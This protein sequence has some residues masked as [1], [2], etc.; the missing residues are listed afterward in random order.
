MQSPTGIGSIVGGHSSSPQARVIVAPDRDSS[1][2]EAGSDGQVVVT[3]GKSKHVIHAS[4]D[5]LL[6][7][8]GADHENVTLL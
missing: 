8:G 2:E 3:T 6:L 7:D 4:S 5:G 1:N